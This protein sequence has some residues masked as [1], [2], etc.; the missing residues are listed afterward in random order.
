MRFCVARL[1]VCQT[2]GLGV[3]VRMSR[4]NVA[5]SFCWACVC[6]HVHVCRCQ[7]A[8]ACVQRRKTNTSATNRACAL[9]ALEKQGVITP[10]QVTSILQLA[11]ASDK[12]LLEA[13]VLLQV[14]QRF[15]C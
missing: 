7:S 12:R 6:V 3:R 11:N 15:P 1:M 9:Q 14:I 8:A 13:H 4:L 10:E 5:A 2:F